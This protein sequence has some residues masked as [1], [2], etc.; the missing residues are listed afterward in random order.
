MNY[1]LNAHLY[2]I[3]IYSLNI[4]YIECIYIY[5]II[6]YYIFWYSLYHVYI[7]SLR[8]YSISLHISLWIGLAAEESWMAKADQK[9]NLQ[10]S[11]PQKGRPMDPEKTGDFSV[12]TGQSLTI[13]TI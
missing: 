11:A 1:V 4:V 10:F 3:L 6:I 8:L 12:N 13:R 5:D 7:I 2:I 9:Q